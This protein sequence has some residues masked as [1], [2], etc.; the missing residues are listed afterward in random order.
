MKCGYK[1]DT[2]EDIGLTRKKGLDFLEGAAFE[3]YKGERIKYG[4][5]GRAG[6]ATANK[7]KS[8]GEYFQR[9]LGV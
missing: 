2:K 4:Y 8:S 7:Q 5:K 6:E 1:S 9:G 3:Q